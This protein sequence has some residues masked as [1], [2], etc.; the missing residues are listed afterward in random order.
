[1]INRRKLLLSS[2]SAF[3][4]TQLPGN[5]NAKN[6]IRHYK[7]VAEAAEHT[8]Y[9]NAKKSKL[10]LYNQQSPGPTIHAVKGDILEVDFLNLLDQPTTI[11]WHGI[12]NL[13][14]MDG[15]PGLTQPAVEP[16]ETFTYRFPLKDTGLFWY[17]AHTQAWKQVAKG[18]YGP[19]L[20]RDVNDE[21]YDRDVLLV[22]DDWLLNDREQLQLDSFGSLHDWS[23]GGR[24][25]NFLTLN[26]RSKPDIEVPSSGQCKLRFLN[27]ANARIMKFELNKRIPMEIVAID[28]SPCAPFVIKKLTVAPAQRYDV[29]IEDSS[30]LEELIEVSTS[31]RLM[32]AGFQ[33]QKILKIS[34]I[35]NSYINLG[36]RF[37]KQPTQ[38][39]LIFICKE[40]QWVTSHPPCLKVKKKACGTS[41]KT[42]PNYGL[43]TVRSVVMD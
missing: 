5:V 14:D 29:L 40:V 37:L 43:L 7:L 33:P 4:L 16:G 26:G 18:L 13:N 6:G 10:S 20:V 42:T 24:H 34:M 8:F 1:M 39:S 35:Q 30:Q 36:I 38:K 22:I 15:V 23:H 12:R 3:A 21:S 2:G 32:A 11:H 25:G 9:P 17:H 19:L 31:E 28:G 27:A 41:P